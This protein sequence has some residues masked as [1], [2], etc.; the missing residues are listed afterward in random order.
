MEFGPQMIGRRRASR[1]PEANSIKLSGLL[2]RSRLD[3]V[4]VVVVGAFDF[5]SG[6]PS[7]RQTVWR[8][9]PSGPV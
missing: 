8:A 7:G 3:V 4:V 2:S 6:R 9:R 1:C 5:A